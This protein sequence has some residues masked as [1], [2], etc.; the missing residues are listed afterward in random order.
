M[1]KNNNHFDNFLLNQYKI[2]KRLKRETRMHKASGKNYETMKRTIAS[3]GLVAM[4][5]TALQAQSASTLSQGD[6]D[7]DWSVSSSLRGFYDDNFVNQSSDI[8][9]ESWGLEVTPKVSYSLTSVPNTLVQAGVGN[10]LRYYAKPE[11]SDQSVEV[12]ALVNHRFNKHVDVQVDDRF[13]LAQEPDVM[14]QGVVSTPLRLQ[15]DNIH[16]YGKVGCD[17]TD[18]LSNF[19]IQLSYQNDLYA[20]DNEVYQ[21]YLDRM[22]HLAV[23]SFQYHVTATTTGIVDYQF[24]DR[25]YSDKIFD[26]GT[27]VNPN[28]YSSTIRN[29]RSHAVLVGVSQKISKDFEAI[30]RV[31]GQAFDYYNIDKTEWSPE[32]ML[33]LTW[34]Y[35]KTGKLTV[36]ARYQHNATDIVGAGAIDSYDALVLD[37]KTLGAYIKE[38]QTLTFISPRLT[39]AAYGYVQHS[40]FNGGNFSSSSDNEDYYVADGKLSYDIIVSRLSADVGYTYTKLSSSG[41][42][43]DRNRVYFGLTAKL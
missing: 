36:G 41:R 15:G 9:K 42:P 10:D 13:V 8:A 14:E 7:K 30:A 12:T 40:K 26:K 35:A 18:V 4:G 37:Q 38:E 22:E 21:Q 33:D 34:R 19:D 24:G 27:G 43:F 16:N 20:Y 23:A 2:P 3:I 32:A 5:V 31:G 17:L 25:E 28:N 29:S 6:R 39:A 11:I 1:Q